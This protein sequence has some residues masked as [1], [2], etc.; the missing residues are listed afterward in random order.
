MKPDTAILGSIFCN[1]SGNYTVQCTGYISHPN[2]HR[3]ADSAVPEHSGSTVQFLQCGIHLLFVES[4][5]I[6]QPDI[7]AG[8]LKE[9]YAA[10]LIF[11]VMN[12]TA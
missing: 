12:R 9:L 10:K 4:A 8:F 6:C 5:L 3:G 11:Q 2:N 1:F 7:A